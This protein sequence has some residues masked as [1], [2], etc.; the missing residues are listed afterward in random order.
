M[1]NAG[2][3]DKGKEKSHAGTRKTAARAAIRQCRR[4]LFRAGWRAGEAER[5]TCPAHRLRAR[6]LCQPGTS[7]ALPPPAHRPASETTA[8]RLLTLRPGHIARPALDNLLSIH[9]RFQRRHRA[10]L[11]FQLPAFHRR[12]RAAPAA[13]TSEPRS[14]RR[15]VAHFS[16]HLPAG[17]ILYPAKPDNARRGVG[18]P[19][20]GHLRPAFRPQ[21]GPGTQLCQPDNQP[22]P[23]WN[24]RHRPP[25]RPLPEREQLALDTPRTTYPL[26]PRRFLHG[27]GAHALYRQHAPDHRAVRQPARQPRTRLGH[28]L[29]H[30][31][32]AQYS[33]AQNAA[34]RR[35]YSHSDTATGD[36]STLSTPLISMDM[37]YHEKPV[38]V[39]YFA[40]LVMTPL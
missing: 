29:R 14:D 34:R 16:R 24:R 13:S 39:S 28:R 38:E 12:I 17:A 36:C 8:R 5:L 1:Y 33:N 7:A 10:A 30:L 37:S 32:P 9:Q 25:A 40:P 35:D 2:I 15:R 18:R 26:H 4:P 19:L 20:R 3:W 22:L 27:A 21:S 31:A 11:L 23:G 6:F